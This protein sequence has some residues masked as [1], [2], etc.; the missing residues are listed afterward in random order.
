[1]D[2]FSEF[3]EGETNISEITIAELSALGHKLVQAEGAVEALEDAL[4]SAKQHYQDLRSKVIPERLAE[5]QVAFIGLEDGRK[6][7]VVDFVSGSLPKDPEKRAAAIAWLDANGGNDLL[8]TTVSV[9][10]SRTQGNLVGAAVGALQQTLAG[11]DIPVKQEFG[12]HPQTLCAWAR[13]R[14]EA[15]ESVDP[16]ALELFVGRVAKIKDAPKKKPRKAA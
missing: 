5:A 3:D 2:G 7:E 1:M 12:V 6:I 9:D 10:F 11:L 8:G 15:G 13:Q 4:K 16:D 14:L